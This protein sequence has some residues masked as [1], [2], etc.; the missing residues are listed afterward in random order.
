MMR[1]LAPDRERAT[2]AVVAAAI[3]LAAPSALGQIS[4]IVLGG[5]IGIAL[6]RTPEAPR[7]AMCLPLTVSRAHGAMALCLFFALLIGLPFA[8]STEASN[9]TL[10]LFDSFYRSGSLVFGGGHVVLPR[11][12]VGLPVTRFSPATGQ[13][14]QSQVPCSPL[15]LI[16][17]RLSVAGALLSSALSRCFCPP[18]FWSSEPYRFGRASADGLRLRRRSKA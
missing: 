12:G 18:S 8:V 14:R 17:A 10:Q 15:L 1:S 13:H 7:P 4:A 5:S 16:L 9:Q 2:V 6:L 3:A 11:Q